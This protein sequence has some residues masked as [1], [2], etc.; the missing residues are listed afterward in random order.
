[1]AAAAAKKRRWQDQASKAR[2]KRAGLK[3]GQTVTGA[4]ENVAQEAVAASSGQE[5]SVAAIEDSVAPTLEATACA[6]PADVRFVQVF[7]DVRSQRR[8]RASMRV[9]WRLQKSC[10]ALVGRWFHQWPKLPP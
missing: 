8:Q 9:K 7:G 2:K 3:L 4:P 1:M 6:R 10:L 5:V